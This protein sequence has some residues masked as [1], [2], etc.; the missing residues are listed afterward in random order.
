L[1]GKETKGYFLKNGYTDLLR[2]NGYHALV[3]DIN[4][5]GESTIGNLSYFEDIIAMGVEAAE[6]KTSSRF[7]PIKTLKWISFT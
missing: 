2:K 4:G 3:F 1:K 7:L 6:L 5:F